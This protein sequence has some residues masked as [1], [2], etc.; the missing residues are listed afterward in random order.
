VTDTDSSRFSLVGF[1]VSLVTVGV[2]TAAG[3]AVVP[4]VGA[5][6]GTLAGGF[7]AGLALEDRPTVEAGVAGIL[8]AL[9]ILVAG[10]LVGSGI[11]AAVLA[12]GAVDPV[13]LLVSAALSFAVGAFGAH[14]GDDL[15][16]G[17]TE[18]VEEPASRST[19]TDRVVVPPPTESADAEREAEVSA[20]A[21][22]S[23][24]QSESADLELE[25]ND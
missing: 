20:D 8:A 3:L 12:L 23:T 16:D 22:E 24:D 17:L 14:F 25:R 9:G 11:V 2:G 15:R 19:G 1:A 4:V 5:Y 10:T 13:T 21:A 7:V 6:T 18:P